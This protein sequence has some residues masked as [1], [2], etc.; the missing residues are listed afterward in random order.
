MVRRACR[1][2]IPSRMIGADAERELRRLDAALAG[3]AEPHHAR[4]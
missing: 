2:S 3:R 1:R 4:P